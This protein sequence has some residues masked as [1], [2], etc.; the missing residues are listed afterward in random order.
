MK[1]RS[2]LI[3]I[4]MP[5]CLTACT[6]DFSFDYPVTDTH[7]YRSHVS[8][9]EGGKISF[10]SQ[11]PIKPGEGYKVVNLQNGPVKTV[12]NLADYEYGMPTTGKRR[13]LV[14]PVEFPDVTAASKN[15][16]VST[17]EKAFNGDPS[18]TYFTS[19]KDYFYNSSY[20]QL[21]IEFDV[22]D[23]WFTTSK[24]WSYYSKIVPTDIYGQ[25]GTHSN[26]S[27]ESLILHEALESIENTKD[28]TIYDTD[29]N[30]FIDSV[31]MIYTHDYDER[32]NG[33][34]LAWAW[35]FW[36]LMADLSSPIPGGY[37]NYK[38]D[39]VYANDYLWASY[40]FFKDG[41]T[42]GQN[43]DIYTFCHEYSHVLG[44]EDYYDTSYVEHPLDG[45]DMM[46]QSMADHSAYSKM[47]LGWIKETRLIT[48]ES[49]VTLELGDFGKTGDTIVFGNNFDE[50]KGAFQEYWLVE[51]YT[52]SGNN[53]LGGLFDEEGVLVYHIDSTVEY[54]R[55]YQGYVLKNNNSSYG[56]G[57]GT[58][59]NLIEFAK[60]TSSKFVYTAGTQFL[61]ANK[62]N[63]NKRTPYSFTVDKIGNGSATLTFKKV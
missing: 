26:C 16:K 40:Q 12:R 49:N 58:L 19:V 60:P 41:M 29:K 38:Y 31:I 3:I 7:S 37:D 1:K 36:D 22:L 47:A 9:D 52:N 63:K 32:E 59:N 39:G 5:L 21:D 27:G 42:N 23:D 61:S 20:G 43:I 46:D 25:S 48:A 56:D 10:E 44:L 17:I 18:S 51:Y 13:V 53:Q 45:Y 30:G 55:E 28:L 15:Y 6:F 62:D 2:L 8:R 50:T 57:Y 34:E 4:G 35:R 14:I 54:D 11:E 24:N 33:D